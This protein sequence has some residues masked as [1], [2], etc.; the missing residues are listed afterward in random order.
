MAAPS[1]S[2][3]VSVKRVLIVTTSYPRNEGDLGG[4]F[5]E[6]AARRFA[7]E[8]AVEVLAPGRAPCCERRDGV[9]IRWLGGE[10]AFGAPG[11][12]S[13][14]RRAPFLA[15]VDAMAVTRSVQREVA[16]SSA[17]HHEE[18][19]TVHAHWLVPTV[20]PWLARANVRARVVAHA[21]GGDVRLLLALPRALRRT[22][23][24]AI[25]ARAAEVRFAARA[26]LDA[27]CASVEE[28]LAAALR[29]RASVV[30]P[31]LDVE[32]RFP[33]AGS[34]ETARRELR[35]RIE[36]SHD[37]RVAVSLGR[38]IES[39][40]VDLAIEAVSRMPGMH[41]VVVGDGPERAA[42]ERRAERHSRSIRFLGD[43]PRAEAL[44]ILAGADVLLHPSAV[45]AAPTA[46]REARALG[47]PV[48]ACDAGDVAAWAL[49]D[50]ELRC[51][52]RDAQ[53]LAASLAELEAVRGFGPQR[54]NAERVT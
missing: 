8:A 41:L 6:T 52:A 7:N 44:G 14:L 30:L 10:R 13:R 3:R 17:L 27:L 34:T 23:V 40:R 45:E 49:E 37:A 50:P 47:I 42:L 38:L 33:H 24:R 20:W 29:E 16:R 31:E 1:Q 9:T 19:C 51:V 25:L 4:H 21:H 54:T 15:G 28:P 35:W 18:D 5:V 39:K 48:I 32:R 12:T 36:A 43:V 2:T 46:I 53:A 11:F 22:I 26:L